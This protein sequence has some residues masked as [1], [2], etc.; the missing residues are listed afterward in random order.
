MTTRH[1]R[2]LLLFTIFIVALIFRV[3]VIF[4]SGYPPTVSF[5]IGLHSSIIN[6]IIEEE[7]LPLWNPYHMGGEPLQNPPGFELFASLIVLLTGMQQI[8]AQ[9]VIASFFSTF[10]VFPAYLISKKIFRNS[11]TGFLSVFLVTISIAGFEMLA[12]GGFPN[13]I[14][15]Q[16]IGIIFYLFLK[17]TDQPSY[18]NLFTAALLFGSLIITHP[19]S[20]FVFLV[21][22]TVY[23]A[24]L[25]IGKAL[26]LEGV[27]ILKTTRF[28]FMSA[29]L[30]TLFVSPW[31]L[32]VISFY[33]SMLSSGVFLGGIQENA[34]LLLRNRLIYINAL[35][36][37]GSIFLALFIFKK[38][39]GRYIDRESLLLTVWYLAP[40][41]LTQ[42][43]IVGIITDYP[44]FIYFAELPGL[45]ILSAAVF[46][47]FRY[48][49]IAI[50]RFSAHE[51]NRV[52]RAAFPIALLAILSVFYLTSPLSITQMEAIG[53]FLI[54]S[55]IAFYLVAIKRF[56]A[57][58][59]NRVERAAFP[60]ALLAI[61]SVFYLTSPLSITPTQAIAKTD[62]YTTV[63]QP[64]VSVI[65]WIKQRTA[66]SAILVADHPYGWWLSGVAE[67]S[68]LTATPPEFLLYPNEI[69][70]AESARILLETDYYINN[71]LLQVSEDGAYLAR[72]NPIFAIT[73][74][75]YSRP[76][77]YFND[78]ETTIYFQRENL[79]GTI[80]LSDLHTIETAKMTSNENSAVL[81]ITRKNDF[82]RVEKTLEVNRGVRFATL[83]YEI[84]IED[85]ETSIEW[86]RFILHPIWEGKVV[87]NQSMMGFYDI[88]GKVCGQ[89]IFMEHYPK[90]KIYAADK[91]SSVEF[92]YTTEDDTFSKIKFLVGV[93]DAENMKYEEV[94]E[95]YE[96][97][98]RN[99]QQ[100]V[101]NLPII[102]RDYL[103]IIEIYN[104]S[105][106][107]SRNRET[108]PKFS[109]DPHFRVVYN[110]VDVAVF[111][112]SE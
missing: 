35:A 4:R 76:L 65:D 8:V 43:Y 7:N 97:F 2:T 56:S 74:Q 101:A 107:I 104:I 78:T 15:I 32:R 30:G 50:K 54:L 66:N 28:F 10:A 95:K 103:E 25:L 29:A 57:H 22:L 19:L 67:R 24:L 16:L 102:A 64:E 36:V 27:Y 84:K 92:L 46:F 98:F 13:L 60:I 82:L 80:D 88:Y 79:R 39:R 52:E 6:T 38:F 70:V 17:N 83:S 99:P 105:F 68:T 20:L 110:N 53:V 89:T 71:G 1:K 81:T 69:E 111:Q 90:T 34:S 96:E 49:A 73:K 62:F 9:T 41:L 3:A 108:Y 5:D 75:G 61:L 55:A 100:I 40:L 31:L 59:W 11:V 12:W 77:F 94:L 23:L 14:A 37:I 51:W 21:I 58:E 112:V 91:M 63:R 33:Y 85:E 109:S 26:K 47:L 86:V 106:I 87:L 48:V 72:H 18:F 44:R 93:F 42:S 45:I